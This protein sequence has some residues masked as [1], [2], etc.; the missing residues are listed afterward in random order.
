MEKETTKSANAH[1]TKDAPT[2]LLSSSAILSRKAM[3]LK[4]IKFNIAK[5]LLR[6]P[7]ML[8]QNDS[9]GQLKQSVRQKS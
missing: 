3:H 1:L 5:P 2:S 6:D 4:P 8:T 7:V 9:P